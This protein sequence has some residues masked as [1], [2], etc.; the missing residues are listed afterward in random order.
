[1][2][3]PD[4]K[5]AKVTSCRQ[6]PTYDGAAI[7]ASNAGGQVEQFDPATSGALWVA[8]GDPGHVN[9]LGTEVYLKATPELLQLA[10]QRF[11]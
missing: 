1:M 11:E 4:N 10:S 5:G 8:T 6:P 2:G 9:V 7:S 3:S